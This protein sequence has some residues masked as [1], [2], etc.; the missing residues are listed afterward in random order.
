MLG[1]SHASTSFAI[2]SLVSIT[3]MALIAFRGSDS[4]MSNM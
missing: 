1:P 2:K 3:S 4:A